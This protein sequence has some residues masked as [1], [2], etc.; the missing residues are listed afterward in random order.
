M[1]HV[2]VHMMPGRSEE[3]KDGL[4]QAITRALQDSI[5]A[6]EESVSVD[7]VDRDNWPDF[8]RAEIEP[9]LA[10]LRKTPGYSY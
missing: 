5:D 10:R 1:P 9:H 3:Q 6:S 8:Y 7:I 4:A 2:V